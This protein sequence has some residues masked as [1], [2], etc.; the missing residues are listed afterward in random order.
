MEALFRKNKEIYDCLYDVFLFHKENSEEKIS[1]R[2]LDCYVKYESAKAHS[3]VKQ[4]SKIFWRLNEPLTQEWEQIKR[5][6][7]IEGNE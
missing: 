7:N 5:K 3:G 1:A 2:I 4:S 6:L